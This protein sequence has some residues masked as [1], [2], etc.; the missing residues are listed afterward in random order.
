[1][2]RARKALRCSLEAGAEGFADKPQN[3]KTR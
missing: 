3:L 1:L 2:N